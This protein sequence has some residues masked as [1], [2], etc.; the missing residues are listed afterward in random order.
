MFGLSPL[1]EEAVGLTFV[2]NQLS[3]DSPYGVER[4]KQIAPLGA[5]CRKEVSTCFDNLEKIISLMRENMAIVEEL[6]L[7]LMSL[8][9]I[10]GSI[11]KCN[12]QTLSQIEMFEVKNFLLTFEK[13]ER[14]FKKITDKV[15]FVNIH[16]QP[17]TEALS[18]LDPNGLRIAA[19]T[20]DSPELQTIRQEKL[21]VEALLQRE[22]D[23]TSKENLIAERFTLV[24]EEAVEESRVLGELSEK[25]RVYLSIFVSNMDHIGTLDL[26]IAK[27]LLALKYN[28]VRPEI[29]NSGALAFQKMSNPYV[30]DLLARNNQTMTKISLAMTKGLT[31][32][33]GA[34]MGGKSVSIK[35]AVLNTMLCQ[36]GFFVFAEKAEIPLFDGIYFISE[37][38]QD[39]VRGLSSFGAEILRFNEIAGHLKTGFLFVALDE[40]ARGTNPHE[41]ASI[42]RAVASYLSDSGS[43]CVMVTHY[44]R[45]V[46]PK[47]RHYQVAGLNFPDK[48]L[49]AK[50]NPSFIAAYMDYNLIEMESRA[51]PPRDALNICKL[52]GLDEEVLNR[53]E[54]EYMASTQM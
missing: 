40:F 8:K 12:T 53:I 33:T 18:V 13:L 47:F 29:S 27:A 38:R 4:K 30:T 41:G 46:S 52:I 19:F 16:L 9:N 49:E 39:V 48:K 3:P 20:L 7:H 54:K 6:R 35:T 51:D 23:Q 5:H 42:V 32:I 25:L 36:I 43:V 34:N 31:I 24:Q 11:V 15:T 2:L 21:R 17:M 1:Q 44:D 37:E 50:S 14:T 10:R 45:I 26:T 28:A 22:S